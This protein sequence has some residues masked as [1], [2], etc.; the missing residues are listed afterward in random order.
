MN[1]REC[2]LKFVREPTTRRHNVGLMHNG[3]AFPSRFPHHQGWGNKKG[4]GAGGGGMVREG[5]DAY[6]R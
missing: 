4:G 1:P 5:G 6:F 2:A 3:V